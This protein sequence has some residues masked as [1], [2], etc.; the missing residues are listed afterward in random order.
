[1]NRQKLSDCQY[2]RIP[3][4]YQEQEVFVS[5]ISMPWQKDEKVLIHD[6]K[7]GVL[8]N[9]EKSFASIYKWV[10][11]AEISEIQQSEEK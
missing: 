11:F 7:D 1:M 3:V 4:L 5:A 8:A 6:C 2:H 10:S 9:Q